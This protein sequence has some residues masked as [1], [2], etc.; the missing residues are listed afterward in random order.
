MFHWLDYFPETRLRYPPSFDSRVVLYPGAKEVRDYFAWR[1]ADSEPHQGDQ[2]PKPCVAELTRHVA[3]INNLYNT[4]FWALV[5]D[6]MTP[7]EANMTLQVSDKP[8]ACGMIALNEGLRGPILRTRT[9][10]YS[11]AS[12]SITTTY[13]RSSGKEALCFVYHPR[14]KIV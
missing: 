2:I 7:T 9:S 8:D 1:Q 5:K 11:L 13:L 14:P 6:E 12:G 3:H 10:S 4:T